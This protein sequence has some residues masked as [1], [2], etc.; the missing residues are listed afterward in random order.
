MLLT[1]V[2]LFGEA[3]ERCLSGAEGVSLRKVSTTLE[4]L[5][6]ALPDTPVDVILVDVTQDIDFRE[7]GELA[8]THPDVAFIAVGLKEQA[9]H[10]GKSGFAGYVARDASIASLVAAMADASAGRLTCSGELASHLLRAL[11][12][13]T[14]PRILDR[15]ASGTGGSFDG[16][17]RRERDVARLVGQGFSNKEIARDLCLS[18]ATVKHHVHHVLEKL[19]LNRR[20]QVS[21]RLVHAPPDP[22]SHGGPTL[23]QHAET[24]P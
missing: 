21:A 11:F 9:S 23:A 12:Q 8:A 15:W 10:A 7:V 1:S 16:L 18:L 14:Q 2:R 19:Q 5:R 13:Q 20:A 24:R 6:Q 22:H 4:E 3:L 17:T